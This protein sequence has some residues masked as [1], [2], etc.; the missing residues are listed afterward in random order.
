MI[1]DT[2]Q[3]S[4]FSLTQF[5]LITSSMIFHERNICFVKAFWA[6]MPFSSEILLLMDISFLLLTKNRGDLVER[7][8][9]MIKGIYDRSNNDLNDQ[10]YWNK[11]ERMKIGDKDYIVLRK[12]FN[13]CR[14][15]WCRI[16][17]LWLIMTNF[18]W[19]WMRT[20]LPS[21]INKSYCTKYRFKFN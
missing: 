4:V 9:I 15:W 5:I 18:I 10:G 12:C 19:F 6:R 8:L 3:L 7:N 1:I 16:T 14:W 11:L 17:Y 21:I 20:Y 2:T 13:L